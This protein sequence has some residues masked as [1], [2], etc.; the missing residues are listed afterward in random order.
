MASPFA[1]YET[2]E[3]LRPVAQLCNFDLASR[4]GAVVALEARVS[5]TALSAQSLGVERPG[6]AVAIDDGLFLTIGYLVTEADDVTLTLGTGEQVPAYPVAFDPPTGLALVQALTPVSLT[7]VPIGDSRKVKTEAAVISAGGGGTEHALTAHIAARQPFAGYWEYYLEE[8]LFVEP[9]LPLWSGAALIG[10]TGELIGIGSLKMEQR[11]A[12]GNDGAPLNMFVPAELIAPVLDDM[13][14]GRTRPSRPW[15]GLITAE[16]QGHV[17]ILDVSP[18]G[19]AQR[20]ELRRGDIV[21][22]IAGHRVRGQ[23]DLYQR[24]WALGPPGVTA[25]LT[26]QRE[27]DVFDVELRTADRVAMQRRRRLN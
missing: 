26:L 5:P 12:E 24:L 16:V 15:L 1:G 10:P 20:A 11:D 8:A 2:D 13:K 25:P 19:P 27:R 6:H 3:E 9:A 23:A 17:V 21:H 18:G 7:P 22:R 4:L 14:A